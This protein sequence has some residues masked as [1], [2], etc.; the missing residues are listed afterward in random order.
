MP[1]RESNGVE[2]M[3]WS[4]DVGVVHFISINTE[5]DFPGS[6]EGPGT[7]LG[8]GPFGDQLGWLEADLQKAVANRARVPWII[9]GAHRP[10][11]SSST[12][13][14][15]TSCQKAFEPLFLKYN[16]DLV[17][18]G[19]IHDYERLYSV[20]NGKV[21][22]KTYVNSPAPIYIVN[23]AAGNVE[24]HS[25]AGS[26]AV[27][28]FVDDKH[29]GYGFLNVVNATTLGWSFYSAA[30]QTLIDSITIT[31]TNRLEFAEAF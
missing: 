18:H 17:F 21:M 11:Y 13:G 31:K 10:L 7:Y 28:A 6:P 22:D 24:G 2:N 15:C 25:S 9:V 12:A 30:D 1:W 26:A 14:D 3:W 19:H 16:V 4:A 29:Y 23:G 5:T 8:G 27:A 20:A